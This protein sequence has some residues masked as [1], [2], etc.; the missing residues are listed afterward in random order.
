MS[1]L[2]RIVDFPCSYMLEYKIYHN[3][4][5]KTYGRTW[6]V[7]ISTF[8]ISKWKEYFP[9]RA[10]FS[11][12][13]TNEYDA[14]CINILEILVVPIQKRSGKMKIEMYPLA[15]MSF[16]RTGNS[17]IMSAYACV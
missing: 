12:F 4:V 8:L 5:K 16:E 15:S 3:N 14:E 11:L 2:V 13:V 7:Q 17:M 1:T 9:T 6:E 10:S